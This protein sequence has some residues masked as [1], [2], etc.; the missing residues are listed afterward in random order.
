MIHP[1][2]MLLGVFGALGALGGAG[3]FAVYF[4]DIPG[5]NINPYVAGMLFL[6]SL[7]V[8]GAGVSVNLLSTISKR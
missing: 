5:A 3:M 2:A 7:L 1:A 4:S 6:L 8:I